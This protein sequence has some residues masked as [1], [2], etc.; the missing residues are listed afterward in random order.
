MGWDST[1]WLRVEQIR[2]WSDFLAIGGAQA[3]ILEVSPGWNRF[4]SRFPNRSYRSLDYPEHDIVRDRLA[5][6]FDIVIADQ[7]IEH[8]SDPASAVRNMKAMLRPGGHLMIAAPFLFRV[9]ARP[10]DFYRWTEAGLREL[11]IQS[12]F[13]PDDVESHAWGNRACARAHIGGD[14]LDYG[15]GRPMENEPEYPVMVWAFA[16]NG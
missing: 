11:L 4:W 3:D 9:H 6:Q 14:I 1:N 5:E 7:V 15:F 13:A 2:S 8:V 12:G 16:R 10:N